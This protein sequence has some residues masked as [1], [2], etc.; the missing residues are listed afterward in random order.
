MKLLNYWKGGNLRI[1]EF[2]PNN[3]HILYFFLSYMKVNTSILILIYMTYK[4][5]KTLFCW[6]NASFVKL[7]I[8][9]AL[10]NG[11]TYWIEM[12]MLNN[13]QKYKNPSITKYLNS[14]LKGNRIFWYKLKCGKFSPCLHVYS[15]PFIWET[16]TNRMCQIV[17]NIIRNA[18]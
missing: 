4:F 17:N 15:S 2:K 11:C 6:I 7:S 12:K 10:I 16:K 3:P 5:P 14:S 8:A 1:C 9:N 18:Q 13:N